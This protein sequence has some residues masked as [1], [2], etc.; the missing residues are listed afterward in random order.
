M[1]GFLNTSRLNKARLAALDASQAIIEFAPDG[2]I[3]TANAN[4]LKAMG[5]ELSEIV[6]KHH[7]IFV[8]P[9]L[10]ASPAYQE[11]W[12]TLQSGR[13]LT[14]E[15]PRRTK[16]G[17]EVWLQAS[18]NPLLIG[19]KVARVVKY[20]S[21]ITERVLQASEDGAQ[22][23]AIN[24][25]QAVI[26]FKP[27]GIIVKANENFC[28]VMGFEPAELVGRHHGMF[29]PDEEQKT[30]GYQKFG[31]DLREGRYHSGEFLRLA[32][33]RREVWLQ[34]TY[35]PILAPNGQVAGVVMFAIDV[36]ARKQADR[37]MEVA[38]KIQ[39]DIGAIS[40]AIATTNA[41]ASSAA[42]ASSQT[43]QNVQAVAA[44]VEELGASIDEISRQ[45]A[46]ASSVTDNAVRQANETD[47]IV[48]S[49]ATATSQIDQVV[50]LISSIAAQTNLLALNATIEAAR[51]G[52]A[53]KGFAVVASEVKNLAT[54]TARAT[55]GIAS[56]IASVQDATRRA[57]SSIR[58]ISNIVASINEIAGSIAAAVGE[59]GDVARDMASN[60]QTAAGGVAEIAQSV[61]M[62]ADVTAGAEIAAHQIQEAARS[63]VA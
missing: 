41:Q 1:P 29:V 11:F 16:S 12:T 4:F 42:F 61:S 15:F 32:K 43:S 25:S 8:D 51:A 14:S 47:A 33:G 3:L 18:Y 48:G 31:H 5:Y 26:F 24:R 59:Q 38:A 22:V 7:R 56:Q 19:G 57:V 49:L 10:A 27:D 23:R 13:F 30:P 44:A 40:Q 9:A 2:T 34:A 28:R 60:M 39:T 20:A 54:Q 55:E 21:I 6:G 62:I 50:Q 58:E 63:L 36:T 17:Q 37:R 46:T 35:N 52:D 53:G 45:M